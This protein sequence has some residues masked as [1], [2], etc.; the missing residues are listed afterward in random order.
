MNILEKSMM[1]SFKRNLGEKKTISEFIKQISSLRRI[2][3]LRNYSIALT[4]E[5][6]NDCVTMKKNIK[7]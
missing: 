6:T 7:R 5:Q 1:I 3:K 2:I 4:E